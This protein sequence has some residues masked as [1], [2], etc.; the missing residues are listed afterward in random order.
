MSM[1]SLSSWFFNFM[2]A[3]TFPIVEKAIGAS[4]FLIFAFVC[5]L[6]AILLKFYMPETRGKDISEIAK[7]VA[8]GFRS[9]P[10]ESKTGF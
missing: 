1:G 10:L 9:H 4:V 3:M 7:I 2:V 8:D 6:L 5:L